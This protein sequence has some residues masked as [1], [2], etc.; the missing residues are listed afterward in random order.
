MDVRVNGVGGFNRCPE[1]SGQMKVRHSSVMCMK[2]GFE[3]QRTFAG[4]GKSASKSKAILRRDVKDIIAETTRDVP[5]Q[6]I[7]QTGKV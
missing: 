1:C 4:E 5:I 2:C 7:R 6:R 3:E